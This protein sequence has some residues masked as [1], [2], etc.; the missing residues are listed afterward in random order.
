M[1]RVDSSPVGPTPIYYT[2]GGQVKRI[3]QLALMAA[4]IVLIAQAGSLNAEAPRLQNPTTQTVVGKKIT[5][6]C[7]I[8]I[9]GTLPRNETTMGAY[10]SAFDPATC[11]ASV[12][13]GRL[14]V[15]PE[16]DKGGA[17]TSQ[18]SKVQDPA[19]STPLAATALSHRTGDLKAYTEDIVNLDV[20][21]VH[22]RVAYDYNGTRNW[23]ALGSGCN[24]SWWWLDSTYWYLNQSNWF[25]QYE[26]NYTRVHSSTY[27][28]Y[29]NGGFCPHQVWVNYARANLWGNGNGTLSWTV[30]YSKSGDGAANGCPPLSGPYIQLTSGS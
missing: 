17:G 6:G 7:Y 21:N 29:G 19:A 28:Q 25:C 30:G 10:E 13:L 24:G 11:T 12:A 2:G 9:S 3:F 14:S 4:G 5:G 16:P 22:A 1:I 26:N 23:N 20:N 27:A 18:W 8:E 15:P